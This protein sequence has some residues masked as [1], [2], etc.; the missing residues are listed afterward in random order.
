MQIP[1][2]SIRSFQV[3]K[4]GSSKR[5]MLR[6]MVSDREDKPTLDFGKSFS[7]RDAIRDMLNRLQAPVTAPQ[8]KQVLASS[9][10]GGPLV[11]VKQLSNEERERRVVLLQRK[12]VFRLHKLVVG[13]GAVTDEDF[14]TAMRYRYKDN[15][16]PRAR[17]GLTIDEDDDPGSADMETTRNGTNGDECAHNAAAIVAAAKRK[18]VPSDAFVA[19]GGGADGSGGFGT[20]VDISTWTSVIPTSAQRHMVF[21]GKP[22]VSRAYRET[23]GKGNMDEERFWT[24]FGASSWG[25]RRASRMTKTDTARTAEADAIFAPFESAERRLAGNEAAKRAR[26]LARELDLAHRDDHRGPHVRDARDGES[27]SMPSMESSRS[28]ME[29]SSGLRLVRLV[30]R[31][32]AMVLD[33]G[34][35]GTWTT[36][37]VDKARPLEDLLEEQEKPTALLELH[38]VGGRGE[39]EERDP[40]LSKQ[41]L[42]SE[43]CADVCNWFDGWNADVARFSKPVVKSAEHLSSLLM[44]MR[45]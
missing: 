30:N 41:T 5:A 12:E 3:S 21:M 26:L 43:T 11:P 18:G 20:E 27:A 24:L 37:G 39:P 34:G 4:E 1:L 16:E 7:D 29:A 6:L 2:I 42:D 40:S 45:P 19:V 44:S 33:E 32:G 15:G 36:D 14:W 17:S 13:S 8:A 22:A 23:V 38:G 25:K 28:G 31:H 9:S 35:V 10:G